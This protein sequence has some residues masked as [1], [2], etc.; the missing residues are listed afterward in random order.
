MPVKE[1]S[2][3]IRDIEGFT[4]FGR[5]EKSVAFIIQTNPEFAELQSYDC[6]RDD[7]INSSDTKTFVNMKG[8]P[9]EGKERETVSAIL[10]GI[11]SNAISGIV[12]GIIYLLI[13]NYLI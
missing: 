13:K 2:S 8:L 7:T 1:Y 4:L 5:G 9:R 6:Y 3:H 11:P 10:Y 12:M